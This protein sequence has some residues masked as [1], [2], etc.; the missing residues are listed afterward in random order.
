MLGK[1]IAFFILFVAIVIGYNI[2]METTKNTPKPKITK[3]KKESKEKKIAKPSSTIP[4]SKVKNKIK[5]ILEKNSTKNTK[6]IKTKKPKKVVKVSKI[7]A[8]TESLSERLSTLNAN[9]GDPIFIRIFKKERTL[10]VWIKP[11]KSK[12]Y[13]LLKIY[14]ICNY[15]GHLGP[16]LKEGDKQAPEGFYKV[17][18]NSLNPNSSYHLSF[19]LG[20]PNQYDRVHHRT[21]SYLMVHG[22]CVSVGC[23]AMGNKNIEDIY[24]LV[25][26]ALDNGQHFVNVHIFPFKMEHLQEYKRYKWYNFWRNLK[27]GYDKFNKTKKPPKISV[28]HKRYIIN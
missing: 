17:Y 16:K 27:E 14:K 20:Y 10:E 19:N 28:R 9:S 4:I 8:L 12:I 21:G 24:S 5:D 15:S 11:P 26:D 13:K 3:I 6:K 25:E 7:L 18:K 23:Y 1:F 22:N 2:Y